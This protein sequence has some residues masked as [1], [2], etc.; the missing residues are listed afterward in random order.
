MHYVRNGHYTCGTHRSYS[1]NE[2]EKTNKQRWTAYV[3]SRRKEKEKKKK[4]KKKKK[5]TQRTKSKKKK[6]KIK[7]KQLAPDFQTDFQTRD[8]NPFIPRRLLPHLFG[9]VHFQCRCACL[10]SIVTMFYRNSC[11]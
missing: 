2:E 11:I 6:K 10:V 9:L 1:I 5:E 7:T 3:T 4:K 8:L